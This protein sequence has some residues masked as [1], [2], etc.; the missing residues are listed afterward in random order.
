[1][2]RHDLHAVLVEQVQDVCV[3][4]VED[5]EARGGVGDAHDHGVFHRV[6]Q[7]RRLQDPRR[8]ILQQALGARGREPQHRLHLAPRD[9]VA[10]RDRGDNP[11][12]TLVLEAREI[13]HRVSHDHGVGIVMCSRRRVSICVVRN[14]IERTTPSVSPTFTNSPA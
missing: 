10:D 5:D 13:A 8:R 12:A 4:H 11:H 2:R 3:Q 6:V 9:V 7:Q 1:V 14:P